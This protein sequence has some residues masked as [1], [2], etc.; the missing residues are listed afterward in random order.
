MR[1]VVTLYPNNIMLNR[2]QTGGL[3]CFYTPPRIKQRA[4]HVLTG[5][6]V[7]N[8]RPH[9]SS[10][11]RCSECPLSLSLGTS[12][13]G[14]VTSLS[15]SSHLAERRAASS[16]FSFPAFVYSREE[17]VV[18][19]GRSVREVANERKQQL[20]L[21]IHSAMVDGRPSLRL[22]DSERRANM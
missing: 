11:A 12:V 16:S 8:G 3:G 13:T 10:L 7:R 20:L 1:T 2:H 21:S 17:G 19:S 5:L 9:Y 14:L 6:I 18:L 4:G 15:I 22:I